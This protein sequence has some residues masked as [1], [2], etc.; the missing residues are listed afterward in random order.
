MVDVV[1]SRQTLIGL[2][3]AGSGTERIP[4]DPWAFE[5][6]LE[7]LDQGELSDGLA[8]AV[9]LL[10]PAT[11][12]ADRRFIGLSR[13]F[14]RLAEAGLITPEGEGA[15]AVLRADRQWLQDCAKTRRHLS[16]GDES[17]ILN[18]GQRLVAMATM[19][20]KKSAA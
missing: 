9:D 12:R 14:R 18:A 20:S 11:G 3:W 1:L 5:A 2:I 17:E 6:A 8:K 13:E 16:D 19:L 10:R 7:R 15:T 4:A